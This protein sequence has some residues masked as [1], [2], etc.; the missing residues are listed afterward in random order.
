MTF[1]PIELTV[2]TCI[3]L[4]G[5][6]VVIGGL[7]DVRREGWDRLTPPQVLFHKVSLS[8]VGIGTALFTFCWL[9]R[10]IWR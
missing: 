1:S 8:A 4:A 3:S 6:L 2:C 5:T 7:L 10:L 9:A